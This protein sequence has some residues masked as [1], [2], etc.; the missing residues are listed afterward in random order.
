MT[1][2]NIVHLIFNP[3]YGLMMIPPCPHEGCG[4]FMPDLSCPDHGNYGMTYLSAQR[5]PVT[6]VKAVLG[7]PQD[8]AVAGSS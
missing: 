7:I 3:A 5:G 8:P 6:W 1:T 2:A 4:W